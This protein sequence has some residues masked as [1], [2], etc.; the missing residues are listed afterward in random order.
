MVILLMGVSGAGKTAVGRRLAERLGWTFHDGDDLHPPANVRKMAAGQPLDDDD[1]R[2]WLDAIRAAIAAEEAGGRD[3]IF[4]CSALKEAYRRRLTAG[5]RDVRIVYLR[6]APALIEERLR[7]RRGHFFDARLLPSQLAT[8]EEP[9]DAVVV[10][11]GAA[12]E[13]VVSRVIRALGLVEAGAETD[14]GE[15]KEDRG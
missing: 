8:L 12:L 14:G 13:V 10:D 9:A 7:N 3:A 15:E 6:G 5:T 4:A 11:V 2:P 1:R